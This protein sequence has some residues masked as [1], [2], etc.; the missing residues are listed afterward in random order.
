MWHKLYKKNSFLLFALLLTSGIRTSELCGT[1]NELY[2]P[3]NVCT[4]RQ[5]GV[6]K[7]IT[8]VNP[9]RNFIPLLNFICAHGFEVHTYMQFLGRYIVNFW[10]WCQWCSQQVM[11]TAWAHSV[12]AWLD[13]PLLRDLGTCSCHEK[14]DT[15]ESLLRPFSATSTISSVLRVCSLHVHMKFRSPHA[16]TTYFW[17]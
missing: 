16:N 2:L 15:L 8:M 1:L 10:D 11:G 12:C 9:L 7:F 13:T 17:P 14:L 6:M 4:H 3:K 5:E